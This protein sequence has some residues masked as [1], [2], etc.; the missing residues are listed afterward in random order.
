[1]KNYFSAFKRIQPVI[2]K[3]FRNLRIGLIADEL[4]HACL[5][6]ECQVRNVT[7]LNYRL[8]LK[9]WRPD[10]LFVESA[11]HG[12]NK[13]WK[14]KIAAYPDHPERTNFALHRVV[15][16]ARKLGIPCVFWNKEDGVHFERFIDSAALFDIIFT[17]DENCVQRYRSRLGQEVRVE[18]LMFA[19]Q[20]EIHFPSEAGYKHKRACFLGSYSH[21]IHDRRRQWQDMLFSTS[22]EIGLTVFDRNSNRKSG[23]Y[24]FP[25]MP[26]VEIRN[27]LSHKKTAQVYRDY[28]VSFN[29]NTIED[30]PTMFSRRLVEIMACGGLAVTTPAKSVSRYFSDYCHVVSSEKETRDLL[31]QLKEGL[32]PKDMEMARAGADYVHKEF[33]WVHRLAKVVDAV[34]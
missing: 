15:E 4:T 28:M 10:I 5:V 26:W 7:P 31:H 2:K 16:Y 27:K 6:H 29:V 25:E 19:V 1:M 30:S 8:I 34:Q 33:T 9:F 12:P 11:W 18:P 22:S 3:P 14:F 24:R 20:P 32:R 21:H 17:V 13:A 23:N